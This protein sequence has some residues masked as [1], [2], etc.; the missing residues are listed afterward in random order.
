MLDGFSATWVDSAGRGAQ[1]VRP[2]RGKDVEDPAALGRP[3][4][5][6]PSAPP[7]QN[8]DPSQVVQN[9]TVVKPETPEKS[10][11][12]GSPDNR[13]PPKSGAT[14]RLPYWMPYCF[15][16]DP[17]HDP[18]TINQNIKQIVDEYGKCGIAVEPFAF[19]LQP[20]YPTGDLERLNDLARQ[21]C[22]FNRA[23][24]VRGAI[25]VAVAD[26]GLPGRMC[27]EPGAQGCSTLCER[28][29]ISYLAPGAGP[30]TAMHES[31]HS[32]CCGR[33]CVNQGE[34]TTDAG[35]GIQL[36]QR[37]TPIRWRQAEPPARPNQADAQAAGQGL[38]GE[39]CASL[40]AGAAPN[41]GTHRWDKN[42][43]NFYAKA[44]DPAA[45]K[46]L[47]GTSFFKAKPRTPPGPKQN[48]GSTDDGKTG[49]GGRVTFDDNAPKVSPGDLNRGKD[50]ASADTDGR[51]R[52]GAALDPTVQSLLNNLKEVEQRSDD[53]LTT[54]F[55][56]PMREV[57]STGGGGGGS[58]RVTFDDN[59]QKIS[60]SIVAGGGT[61]KAGPG[62]SPSVSAVPGSGGGLSGSGS[63]GSRSGGG[64]GGGEGD[65][66]GTKVYGA[67]GSAG[68]ALDGN[69]FDQIKD[70]PIGNEI[71]RRG[72]TLRSRDLPAI[73]RE[74]KTGFS[75]RTDV[76]YSTR[77]DPGRIAGE[78]TPTPGTY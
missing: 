75:Q 67:G 76:L 78:Q 63:A 41:D 34:G 43:L 54:Q 51:H 3:P 8:L 35:Y 20:G 22:D 28:L 49:T 44:T 7:Q 58:A 11:R 66:D 31:L 74:S 33:L 32:N 65:G 9:G 6:D 27:T 24:V 45:Q 25:Q 19:T 13:P 69:F 17:A 23:F 39:A 64:S 14:T 52:N 56:K 4:S 55:T 71:R 53:G 29:S 73:K 42:K 2:P 47:N 30:Q 5:S 15:L 57:A 59:A 21:A 16:V 37:S 46:P 61:N 77:P 50:T 60:K 62:K 10:P 1:P 26:A 40:T 70:K 68:N 48:K 18:T 12:E 36:V 72:D 38:P